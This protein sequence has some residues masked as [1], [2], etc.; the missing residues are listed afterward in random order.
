MPIH[1]AVLYPHRGAR[2]N[3]ARAGD[4]AGLEQL[5]Q[6]SGLSELRRTDVESRTES[7]V[8]CYVDLLKIHRS[9]HFLLRHVNEVPPALTYTLR[10]RQR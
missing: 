2:A 6:Q 8:D 5:E 10:A 7:L 9:G 1:A 3:A 4:R